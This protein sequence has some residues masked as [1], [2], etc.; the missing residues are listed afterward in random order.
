M[1]FR[2]SSAYKERED[3]QD[4]ENNISAAEYARTAHEEERARTAGTS[5]SRTA[6]EEERAR[7]AGTSASRTAHEMEYYG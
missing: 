3:G 4:P 6:H 1:T 5:A 7:T 2:G